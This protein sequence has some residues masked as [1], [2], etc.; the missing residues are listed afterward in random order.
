MV[1]RGL[2]QN[3]VIVLDDG[4][5]L[6]DGMPVRVE[7]ASDSGDDVFKLGELAKSTGVPDLAENIDH[8]LYGHPKVSESG[9]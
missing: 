5:Q 6:P 8:Y 4:V 7:A 3:G 1:Y 9:E 2:V